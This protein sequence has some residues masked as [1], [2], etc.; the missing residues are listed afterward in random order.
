MKKIQIAPSILAAD[1]ARLGEEI[2]IVANAGAELLHIDV[3]DGHF[4]PNITIGPC[5]IRALKRV[6][7]V[8]LDVHLMI[9]QAEKYL[10][11]FVAAGSDWITFHIEA[12][13]DPDSLIAKAK[14]LGVQI[15]IAIKPA[16]QLAEIVK[17]LPKVDLV[18]IMAV[19][20]GFGGQQFRP[21]V[22]TKVSE[23]RRHPYCPKNISIDGGIDLRTAVLASK[24]GVNILVAGTTIF[25]ADDPGEMVRQLK[26]AVLR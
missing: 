18:L 7:P 26:E 24:A 19:E 25:H 4:V 8:I 22:L 3:M 16:T 13:A 6:S 1:F 15:G 14:A 9:T 2:A 21:E 11:T 20:P 23:L 12:V 5:V 17:Y 10:E